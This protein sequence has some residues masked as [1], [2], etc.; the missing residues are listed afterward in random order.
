ME[1]GKDSIINSFG[2]KQSTKNETSLESKKL[3]SAV[4]I[5]A[6]K[7]TLIQLVDYINLKAKPQNS[8]VETVSPLMNE[9]QAEAFLNQTKA[10]ILEQPSN[11]SQAQVN[12]NPD[13]VYNLLG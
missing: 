10:L 9:E 3:K 7:D 11:F 8:T 4:K 5:E 13:D 1:I 12:S 2:N 6:D